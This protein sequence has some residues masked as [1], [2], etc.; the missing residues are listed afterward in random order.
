MTQELIMTFTILQINSEILEWEDKSD[1]R[2][3]ITPEPTKA[4]LME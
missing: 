2:L 1:P 4:G 3:N